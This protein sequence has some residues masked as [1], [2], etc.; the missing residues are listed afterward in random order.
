MKTIVVQWDCRF[1]DP[2]FNF[3]RAME[4]MDREPADIYV[5][6][7][8]CLSGYNFKDRQ[9]VDDLSEESHGAYAHR[10]MDLA[11]SRNCFLAYGFAEKASAG[12][13]NSANLIGPDGLIGTYRKIHLFNRE[14]LFF[15]PGDR[16][17][18]VY[19]TPVGKLGL[20]VCFDWFFPES[21]RTLA[22]QGAELILH[23]SNLVLSWCPDAMRYHALWN[24]VYTAT[25]NRIGREDRG[26]HVFEYIGRSII[27]SPQG[28]LLAEAPLEQEGICS[29]ELDLSLAREKDLNEY[30]DRIQSRQPEFYSVIS[31][32]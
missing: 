22:L 31:I 18:R 15:L 17:F 10:F 27:Y 5:L 13:Y 8:L 32:T 30:N 3:G 19:E 21:A 1:G 29:A 7:E 16:P 26:G 9:E 6:P 28:E 20:M 25:S 11:R 12:I 24:G 2:E 14:T 4:L 23:P